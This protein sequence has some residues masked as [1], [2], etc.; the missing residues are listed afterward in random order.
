MKVITE[1]KFIMNIF[2]KE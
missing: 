2:P 1:I